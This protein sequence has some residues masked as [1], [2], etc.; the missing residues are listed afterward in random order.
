MTVWYK[1]GVIGDLK[2]PASKALRHVAHVFKRIAAQDTYVT[3]LR[4]GNHS[5]GSLHYIGCA[6]DVR[7]PQ[8]N[9]AECWKELKIIFGSRYDL[10]DEKNHWHIEYDPKP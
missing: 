4:E 8:K 1:Q 7:P 2:I 5:A 10:V 3:S 9:A 6:F